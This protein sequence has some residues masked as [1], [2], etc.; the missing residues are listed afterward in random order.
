MCTC[1]FRGRQGDGVLALQDHPDRAL[2]VISI[3]WGQ[4]VYRFQKEVNKHT[5]GDT[6]KKKIKNKSFESISWAADSQ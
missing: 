6:G 4:I 5:K 1:C 3:S 2:N